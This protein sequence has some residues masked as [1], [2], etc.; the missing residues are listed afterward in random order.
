MRTLSEIFMETLNKREIQGHQN[1]DIYS[2][3]ITLFDILDDEGNVLEAML[4]SAYKDRKKGYWFEG[5]HKSIRNSDTYMNCFQINPNPT[6]NAPE[7]KEFNSLSKEWDRVMKIMDKYERPLLDKLKKIPES[8]PSYVQKAAEHQIAYRV[9]FRSHYP[10]EKNKRRRYLLSKIKE[11]EK[12]SING[13]MSTLLW[14]MIHVDKNNIL[15]DALKR[16]FNEFDF[17]KSRVK[18]KKRKII[19]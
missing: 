3:F 14:F 12:K 16:T 8:D 15:V 11:Q 10:E 9:K 5:F 19:A 7:Q 13:R 4:S 18:N 2:V 6:I 17:L 1:Q